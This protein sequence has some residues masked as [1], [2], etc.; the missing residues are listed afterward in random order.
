MPVNMAV[1]ALRS[2]TRRLNVCTQGRKEEEVDFSF[3]WA[4][5]GEPIHLVNN[6]HSL[7]VVAS[8]CFLVA[9]A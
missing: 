6:L 9:F 3:G 5:K 8:A 2:T 7:A 1:M 4:T